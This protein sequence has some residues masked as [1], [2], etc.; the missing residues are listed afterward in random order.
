MPRRTRDSFP[1][2]LSL[3]NSS[4]LATT[5]D[6]SVVVV[7][8]PLT[9]ALAPPANYNLVTSSAAEFQANLVAPLAATTKRMFALA[10]VPGIVYEA[11]GATAPPYIGATLI[12]I[13]TNTLYMAVDT[14]ASVSSW[15]NVTGAGAGTS[16]IF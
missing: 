15:I 1:T 3:K 12:D 7:S 5:A 2:G 10:D 4:D 11:P 6:N 9:S 8:R 14:T 16:N 13:S